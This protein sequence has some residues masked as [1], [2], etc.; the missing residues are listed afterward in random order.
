[1]K[2]IENKTKSKKKSGSFSKIVKAFAIG[3]V[4]G[5]GIGMWLSTEKG[6]AFKGKVIGSIQDWVEEGRS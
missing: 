1:M 3:T 5:V 2:A 6:N 4:T